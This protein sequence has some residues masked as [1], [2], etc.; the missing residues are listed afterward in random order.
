MKLIAKKRRW[1]NLR[2]GYCDPAERDSEWDSGGSFY[3][4]VFSTGAAVPSERSEFLVF[5]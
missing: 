4:T 3:L 1:K 2:K 5:S